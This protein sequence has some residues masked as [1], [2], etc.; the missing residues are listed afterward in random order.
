MEEEKTSVLLFTGFEKVMR[1][2]KE[3]H[4]LMAVSVSILLHI[5]L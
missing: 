5:Q 2:R 4:T 3:T 1:I